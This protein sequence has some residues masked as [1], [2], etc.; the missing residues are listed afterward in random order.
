MI[1][2]I[3][4]L[5]LLGMMAMPVLAEDSPGASIDK[6]VGHALLDAI[7]TQ[8]REMAISG[9]GGPERVD[10]ALQQFMTDARKA[11][12]QKQID[13][14]FFARYRRIVA[15]MKLAIIHDPSGILGA[16]TEQEIAHFVNDI[17]GEEMKATPS[18]QA[19]GQVAM[20]I[21]EEIL[22]LHLYLDDFEAKEKLREAFNK[23]FSEVRPKKESAKED[24]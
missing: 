17:L 3:L 22:N 5:M 10:K 6:K 15:V 14:V 16:I 23:K 1:R 18:S 9:S 2:K 19:L 8:F 24:S 7:T 12:D 21:S 13:Q 20:A 4:C 11:K